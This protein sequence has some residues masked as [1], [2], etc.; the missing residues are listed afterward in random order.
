VFR[1]NIPILV[2]DMLQGS[3]RIKGIVDG[4][5]E[6]ARRDDGVLDETVDLNAVVDN[7]LRLVQNQI[8]RTARVTFEPE[9][10]LPAV[11]GN[12]QKLEQVVVNILINASHAI[13]KDKGVIAIST[14]HDAERRE[15]ILLIG[16]NGT[17]MDERTRR[18]IFDPFFTTKRTQG[19][20]GL[21]L[22]IAHRII[23]E[24]R[25]RI[26]VES[27]PGVGTTFFIHLPVAERSPA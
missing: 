2:E 7:C 11:E 5:R 6:F 3:N 8:K 16:D 9:E 18:Q 22:S 1:S 19:G 24:H 20:T 12:F 15:V 14:R 10:A 21:G 23:R 26:D 27:Q 13:D 25:G 4:L 17:G